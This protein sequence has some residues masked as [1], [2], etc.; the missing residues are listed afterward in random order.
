MNLNR[1]ELEREIVR[2]DKQKL[3]TECL[4]I[5]DVNVKLAEEL[6][7]HKRVGIAAIEKAVDAR[8]ETDRLAARTIWQ[9]INER[10]EYRIKKIRTKRDK[11]FI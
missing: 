3:I 10:L 6:A 7:T 2:Y 4:K 11:T 9:I 5:F 1:D 8:K